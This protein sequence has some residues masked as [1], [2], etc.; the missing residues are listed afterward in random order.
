M[1]GSRGL[2]DTN[3]IIL[4][5]YIDHALLPDESAIS[6][7]T[8]GELTAGIHML[9]GD[10]AEV[11]EERARRTDALARA[12]SEFDPIPYDVA[13]AWIFGLLSAAVQSI[14]RSPRRRTADL[15]IAA[16]A[17][18]RGFAVYTT[19][20]DDFAGIDKIVTVIAV[21]RPDVG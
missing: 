19:N 11:R 1:P 12:E 20:P 3:I 10:D 17:A 14:G 4:R 8:L 13:A 2:L 15:M 5:R 21:P 7:V 18:S 6:A 9:T 16:T